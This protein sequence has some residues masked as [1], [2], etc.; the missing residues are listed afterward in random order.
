MADDTIAALATA[1]G[2]AGVS[3]VRVSGDAALAVVAGIFVPAV[4]E[5]FRA[6]A[7]RRV[8][9]GWLL[10]EPGGERTDDVLA[11]YMPGPH[12]YTGE[13]V[14]EIS[15]HGGGV[16]PRLA[17]TAALRAGARLAEPGEF[18][19]RAFMNGRVDLAQA[20]AT[21][22]LVRARTDEAFRAARRLLSGE[23]SEQVRAVGRR[24]LALLAELEARGD[25]PDLELPELSPALVASELQ[26]CAGALSS[27][28]GGAEQGRLLREGL[29]VVLAGRPNV[30]KSSLL[31]ALLG[32]ERAIVSAVPGTTRDTIEESITIEGVPVVLV[33]TA[34]LREGGDEVEMA[35][36]GRTGAALAGA[37]LALLVLDAGAGWTAGDTA[38]VERL[39]KVPTVVAV[40]KADICEWLPAPA[41]LAQVANMQAVV[42][43]SAQE[44]RGLRE[45]RQAIAGA[46]GLRRGETPLIATV[47][48]RD[49]V[50][51]A[52]ASLGEAGRA[53]LAGT[54]LDL[55][56]VDINAARLALGEITGESAP[57]AVLEAIFARFCIGK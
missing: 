57:E 21:I 48:Q 4:G 35:G 8:Y 12:S 54:P 46:A 27:L 14:V 40:N 15:C 26:G 25:F 18:T 49:A 28:L 36:V 16:A 37:D 3:L 22:D 44:L 17:L 43:V 1:A 32:E 39:S 33:D 6:A 20:E 31:N 55:L 52:M 41:E 29:R 10:S 5:S 19:R 45:L 51:R 11:W 2:E 30:G 13:D 34:G 7:A 23:L 9:Y 50:E 42:S 24:L 38:A 56:A 53:A 47:R